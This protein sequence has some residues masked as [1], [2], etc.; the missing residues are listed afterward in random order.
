LEFR[1]LGPVDVVDD[2]R[3]VPV[4]GAK[5]RALLAILAIHVN[6]V[7]PADRLI[8]ELWPDEPPASALNTLQGYV[9]RLRKALDPDG[10]NGSQPAIAFRSPGYVLSARP[11]QLDVR[12][13]ERLVEEAGK[14]SARG[15]HS[16]AAHLLRAALGLWR[17]PALS[18]F[19]Y[20]PFARAEIARLEELRLKAIEDRI[21]ADLACGRD[22]ELVSELEALVADH[23]LRER[24]RSQLMLALY[25]SG[26]QGDAL[27]VYHDARRTLDEQLGVE[28][29]GALRERQRAILAQDAA[30]DAPAVRLPVPVTARRRRARWLVG[31]L[32][33]ALLIVAIA[34]G[35][36]LRERGSAAPA[37]VAVHPHSVAM[38]DPSSNRVVADLRI[39]GWPRAIASGQGFVWAARTG[40]DSVVRVD[41]V[42]RLVLDSFFATT[43]LDLASSGS[44]IWIA[45]GNSFDGPNPPGGGTVERYDVNRQKLTR[46]RVGPAVPGNAE[47]TVVAAGREGVW[48]GNSDAARV[49]R[50]SPRTGK[51]VATVPTTIQVAGVAVGGGAVWAAD[52]VNDVLV[53]VDPKTARVIARIQVADGPRRLAVGEGAVWATSEFPRSGVW[54]IDPGSNRAV[55]HIAVPRRAAWVSV[56]EGSVWVTSNTPGHAGPARC[57]VSTRR[58]TPS[59][60]RSISASV[61]RAS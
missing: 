48:A 33:A 19:A 5:Q 30:L 28:P 24:L 52:P 53:R 2:G 47:Q 6:E 59:S 8:D 4:G 9:S 41:P 29:T 14:R 18:D 55:A 7:L 45:N 49:Y 12:R 22:T 54:R 38:I 10:K 16:G 61:Q 56:G 15:E 36:A 51:V 13:F 27:A 58:R 3:S 25:R 32:A 26:R 20:E 44:A 40:D 50:L 60:R 57:R 21:D 1:L 39:G 31:A 23:P 37:A 46:T 43:P 42:G 17:G 11:E 35:A 34:V